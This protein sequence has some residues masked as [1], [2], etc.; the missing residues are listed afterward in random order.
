MSIS[1]F[2]GNVEH[3]ELFA[4]VPLVLIPMSVD[5]LKQFLCKFGQLVLISSEEFKELKEQIQHLE[6]LNR[7]KDERI[8]EL[9]CLQ[10][11]YSNDGDANCNFDF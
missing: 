6:M 10:N 8:Q 1:N 11:P 5:E 3:S 9:E 2:A 4:L 7:T